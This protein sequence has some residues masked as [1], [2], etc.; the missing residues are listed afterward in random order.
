KIPLTLSQ[1]LLF[2]PLVYGILAALR[3]LKTDN[4]NHQ[5]V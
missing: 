5:H 4:N 1:F 3:Q 2:V